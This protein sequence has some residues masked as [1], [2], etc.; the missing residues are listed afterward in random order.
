[1]GRR[2][3]VRTGTAGGCLFNGCV[4]VAIAAF[5]LIAGVMVYLGTQPGRD[6]D[7]ARANLRGN[8]EAKREG[9]ARAAADGDLPDSEIARVFPAAKPARGLIAVDRRERGVTVVASLLGLGPTRS[10]INVHQ[11]SVAGC[12]AFDV[13]PPGPG[14][15][16]ITARELPDADCARA[17]LTP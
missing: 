12:Y 3:R 11:R 2:P 13:P 17:P 10:F 6:E 9:L 4:T 8:V 16:R 5:V 14:T 1:M 15:P 7:E